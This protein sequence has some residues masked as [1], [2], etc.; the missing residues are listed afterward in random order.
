MERWGNGLDNML[1]KGIL[2]A[3]T[4][5]KAPKRSEGVSQDKSWGRGIVVGGTAS[6]K[7]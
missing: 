5:E 7:P 6:E 4:F 3:V 1:R 2:A